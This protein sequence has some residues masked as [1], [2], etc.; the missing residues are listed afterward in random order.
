MTDNPNNWKPDAS[1]ETLQRRAEILAKIRKFFADRNVLEVETPVLSHAATTDPNIDS[2][3]TTLYGKSLYLHTSPEFPMKRLLVAGSGPIYQMAKVFRHEQAGRQHNPEFTLLEWYRPGFDLL[4]L[5]DEVDDL[6]EAILPTGGAG[7][8]IILTY[9][10]AFKQYAGIDDIH[11]SAIDELRQVVKGHGIEIEGLD[12]SDIDAWRDL[13]M[14]SIIAPRLGI[15]QWTFVTDY[16]AS[17]A[18]L[19]RIDPGPPAVA[20]RFELF[21]HGMEIANGF[22]E[23]K[24]VRQQRYRFEADN[25]RREGR[26]QPPLPIDGRLLAALDVGL[27]DCVGVALGL[28][29]LIMLAVGEDSISEVLSFQGDRA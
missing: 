21:I 19:S 10:D 28:D 25:D 17:Q 3:V 24:D 13:L 4:Q 14:G 23:L 27:P 1:L 16:P 7:S 22:D 6:V 9:A 20:R 11:T 12:D 18:S 26:G 8:T 5:M 15:E 2:F 29:R